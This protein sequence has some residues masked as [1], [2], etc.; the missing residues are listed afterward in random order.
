MPYLSTQMDKTKVKEIIYNKCPIVLVTYVSELSTLG[1][2][3]FN[4][5]YIY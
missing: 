1:K 3:L 2:D 4:I 5:V